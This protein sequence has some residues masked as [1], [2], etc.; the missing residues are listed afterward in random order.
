METDK[1]DKGDNINYYTN[2]VIRHP[3]R[4]TLRQ[5]L[6]L[7]VDRLAAQPSPG[8]QHIALLKIIAAIGDQHI[9][10][11]KIIAA[12]MACQLLVSLAQAHQ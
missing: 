11:L 12:I 2:N 7:A 9:V 6:L 10:L 4:H 5:R 8:D 3:S 1:T